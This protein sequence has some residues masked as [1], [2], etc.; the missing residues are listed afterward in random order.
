MQSGSKLK[1]DELKK[2]SNSIEQRHTKRE[3]YT[4]EN[5]QLHQLW[6]R[7]WGRQECHWQ[8]GGAEGHA[9]I[10]SVRTPKLQL[11]AEQLLTG[12]CWIPHTK[13]DTP[14]SRAKEK[15]QQDSK[16]GKITFRTK[17]TRQRCLESSNKTLSTPGPRDPTE[18]EPDL[19][20]SLLQRYVSAVASHRGR[21]SGCSYLSH[22][23]CDISPLAGG[24]H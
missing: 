16:R 8:D 1:L 13:I 12:E 11:F 21:G 4:D 23:T 5:H 2:M 18:T 17:H 15:P 14:H 24:H 19:C 6:G 9:L 22:K 20:F 3:I 7:I 10:F